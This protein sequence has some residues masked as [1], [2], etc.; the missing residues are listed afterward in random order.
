MEEAD[1][2]DVTISDNKF[3]EPKKKFWLRSRKRP[4][5]DAISVCSMDIS[6]DSIVGKQ[7]KRRKLSEVASSFFAS[8]SSKLDRTFHGT[9]TSFIEPETTPAR[10]KIRISNEHAGSV[11]IRS[12]MLDVAELGIASTLSRKEIKRQEAIYELFCGENVLLNDLCIL[13]DFYYQPLLASNIFTA[14]ELDTVFGDIS[15]FILIHGKLRDEMVELR[16]R[17]GYTECVGPTLVEWL[18]QLNDLYVERCRSQVWARHILDIKKLTCKRF[19]E[20]LRKRSESLRSSDLWSYIDVPRSR[21]VKYPL[22]VNEILRHTQGGHVDESALKRARDLLSSL[23]KDVDLAMGEAECKLAQSKI[24]V[25]DQ[26]D[27]NF[28]DAL[29]QATDLLCEGI[30]R[31]PKGTKYHCFLFNTCFVLT[32]S[33]RRPHRK[34]NVSFPIIPQ[35]QLKVQAMTPSKTVASLRVG[36]HILVCD[37]EH[38]RR[39]WLDS[40]KRLSSSRSES[41]RRQ[42]LTQIIKDKENEPEVLEIKASDVNRR[43]KNGY[44]DGYFTISLKKTLLRHTRNSIDNL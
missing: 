35:D 25:P 23:L 11:T 32:R 40:F 16:D 26:F 14:E 44:K 34:Y 28:V 1:V 6:I 38:H 31:D 8:A 9:E 24:F 18:V 3:Q 41:R 4:K 43:S 33:N 22:L 27:E 21:I 19:Q 39:H 5:S 17:S 37:D 13:R 10:K 42:S 12:W 2:C 15:K 30:L 7:K 20:F 36:D 29:N